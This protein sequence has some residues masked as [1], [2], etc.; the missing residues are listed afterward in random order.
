MNDYTGHEPPQ[1]TTL[2]DYIRVFF[3]R[4]WLVLGVWII[5]SAAGFAVFKNEKQV[6]VAVAR[7]QVREVESVSLSIEHEFPDL[8][9]NDPGY[10]LAKFNSPESGELVVTQLESQGA[11]DSVLDRWFRNNPTAPITREDRVAALTREIPRAVKV[12]GR[13]HL[14]FTGAHEDPFVAQTLANACMAAFQKFYRGK[15]ETA[16][17]TVLGVFGSQIE[18]AS[19]TMVSSTEK[20]EAFLAETPPPDVATLDLELENLREE[21]G[22]LY[23]QLD[24]MNRQLANLNDRSTEIKTILRRGDPDRILMLVDGTSTLHDEALAVQSAMRDMNRLRAEGK[25]D[26]HFQVKNLMKRRDA[27]Q[28][29]LQEEVN[30]ILQSDE[31][32]AA[33][34]FTYAGILSELRKVRTDKEAAEDRLLEIQDQ[35]QQLLAQRRIVA[36]EKQTHDH[37]RTTLENA[38]G[39]ARGDLV[40]LRGLL[41][42]TRTAADVRASVQVVEALMLAPLP[43]RPITGSWQLKVLFACIAGLVLGLL[44]A[45]ALDLFDYSFDRADVIERELGLP[46][47]AAFHEEKKP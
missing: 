31:L 9:K 42:R 33:S 11:L 21:S 41:E 8:F 6:Y 40:R 24:G 5:V 30:R 4:K 14:S 16:Y 15:F 38:I 19:A 28:V 23:K 46:V 1:T 10:D 45:F 7:A 27:A 35:R 34:S 3:K 37:V 2:R 13:G 32:L 20:L 47:L 39:A 44:A 12:D 22:A 25:S 26:G 17:A 29:L 36:A 18:Q 43:G